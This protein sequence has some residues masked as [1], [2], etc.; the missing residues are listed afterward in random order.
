MEKDK[1]TRAETKTCTL[2]CG[3]G[4]KRKGEKK[5]PCPRC[6]GHKEIIVQVII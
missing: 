6:H 2:C 1:K 3:S 4:K 5:V